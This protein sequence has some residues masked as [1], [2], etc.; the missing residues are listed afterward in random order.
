MDYAKAESGLGYFKSKQK[1]LAE[2]LRQKTRLKADKTYI[3][4]S[5]FGF[6]F[7]LLCLILLAMAIG[8]GNNILYFFVFM[9]I[10]MGMTSAVLTNKNVENFKILNIQRDL[11]FANEKNSLQVQIENKNPKVSLWDVELLSSKSGAIQFYSTT[12]S[13]VKAQ[14]QVEL[15]WQPPLRGK[16]NLPCVMIQSRFPYGLLRSWK[17]FEKESSILVYPQR[18]GTAQLPQIDGSQK[19]KSENEK[20]SDEG[21]FRDFR[22]FQHTD[23][24]SRIDWKRSLKQQKHIVKN[25]EKGGERKILIDWQ[26]TR[27]LGIVEDRIS[28]LALWLDVCHTNHEIFCLKINSFESGY[29]S[30]FG[31]YRNCLEKLA[32]LND[33]DLK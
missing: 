6:A 20:L 25:Y 28:Q 18:K 17:Y 14:L 26:N 5:G 29:D 2:L 15:Q 12:V 30:D 27:H 21:L 11:I 16:T 22:D 23:S 4:P 31:H 3:F 33:E 7:G 1:S 8:Y 24:P 32:L 9:L 10:S 13:E 19:E